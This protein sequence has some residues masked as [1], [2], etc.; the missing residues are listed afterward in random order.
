MMLGSEH[1]HTP[2][3]NFPF[4]EPTRSPFLFPTKF[5]PSIARKEKTTM[6]SFI[7]IKTLLISSLLLLPGVS[8]A[9]LAYA[10]V[11]DSNTPP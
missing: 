3:G 8:A 11:L 9:P 10:D 2:W 1:K 4:G 5:L 7:T 6:P